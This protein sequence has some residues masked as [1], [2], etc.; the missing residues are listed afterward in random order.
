MQTTSLKRHLPIQSRLDAVAIASPCDASWNDMTGNDRVRFCGAC[1][2][3]VYNLSA[4]P[5]VE[6]EVLLSTYE[7]QVCVRLYRRKDGTVLT[8]DCPV[9]VRKRRARKLALCVMGGGFLTAAG[10]LLASFAG[11]PPH[12]PMMGEPCPLPEA[13]STTTHHAKMGA[14]A[15][16]VM[17]SAAPAQPEPPK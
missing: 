10:V 5:R 6:A 7:G 1:K 9:G 8:Q 16:P 12:L 4:M 2:K 15:L 14:V 3:N 11:G 13:T 17:G